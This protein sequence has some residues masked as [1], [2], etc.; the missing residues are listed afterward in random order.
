MPAA[1]RLHQLHRLLRQAA[2]PG[3]W[4]GLILP[5]A[6]TAWLLAWSRAAHP[7]GG[8]CVWL[9]VLITEWSVNIYWQK[10]FRWRLK[11]CDDST[12]W[13]APV[14]SLFGLMRIF[15][16]AAYAAK[17][18]SWFC[19]WP[20]RLAWSAQQL[21]LIHR[22]LSSLALHIAFSYTQRDV[23]MLLAHRWRLT[24]RRW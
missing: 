2:H 5:S 17:D 11:I 12:C 20:N 22:Q 6:V 18:C 15:S 16:A 10:H 24:P 4:N 13:Q 23:M 3:G 1:R 8:P 21:H 14:E 7:G 19:P 9:P